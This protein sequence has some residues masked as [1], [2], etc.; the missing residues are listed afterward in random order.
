MCECV[1]FKMT[2][3]ST[4]ANDPFD[5]PPYGGFCRFE[6]HHSE[7]GLETVQAWLHVYESAPA[8]RHEGMGRC[9]HVPSRALGLLC[10]SRAYRC[11][12]I[13]KQRITSLLLSRVGYLI[14]I[15]NCVRRTSE[16][17]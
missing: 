1:E 13:M 8:P 2:A 12:W 6:R 10:A 7:A 9:A 11:C 14:Q 3:M 4:S 15:I 17:E 5:L 16:L